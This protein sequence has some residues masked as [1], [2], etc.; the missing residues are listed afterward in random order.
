ME[1]Q[2][3]QDVINKSRATSKTTY[4]CIPDMHKLSYAAKKP[5]GPS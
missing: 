3:V 5:P 1:T 4:I 2:I